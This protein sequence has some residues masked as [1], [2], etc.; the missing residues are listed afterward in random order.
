MDPPA[1]GCQIARGLL[2]RAG[3]EVGEASTGLD[4]VRTAIE[5]RPDLVLLDVKLPDIDGF[6]VCRLLR[7]NEVTAAV[8]VVLIS[9]SYIASDHR[10]QG[11]EGGADHYLAGTIEPDL[12]VATVRATLRMRFCWS[13]SR[14]VSV[15][16]V[17]RL[18]ARTPG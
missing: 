13:R 1:P 14:A 10:V 9:A 11:L 12:M 2:T 17:T 8:A 7:E 3:Y 6:E 16:R 18:S 5:W 4:G 15:W